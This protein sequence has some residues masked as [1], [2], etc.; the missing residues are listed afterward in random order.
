VASLAV[1]QGRARLFQCQFVALQR[2]AAVSSNSPAFHHTGH[3]ATGSQGS[4]KRDG[5]WD[6]RASLSEEPRSRIRCLHIF[7]ALH[8][9]RECN[10]LDS[11]ITILRCW[12]PRMA[13]EL[14]VWGP[15]LGLPSIDPDC[16]AAISYLAYAVPHEDWTLTASNDA[17][18]SPASESI[19]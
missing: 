1:T 3:S 11:N 18:L 8:A 4:F 7:T 15:A 6:I 2:L 19:P 5:R 14:H 17:A 13:L 12:H 9:T 16:I 10:F